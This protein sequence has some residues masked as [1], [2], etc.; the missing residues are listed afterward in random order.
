[1]KYN[2]DLQKLLIQYI[3]G[4]CSAEE[5]SRV[6]R[7]IREDPEIK[8]EF[9][10][11]KATW[12]QTS[13]FEL[14]ANKPKSWKKITRKIEDE[15]EKETPIYELG[16]VGKNKFEAAHERKK[17]FKRFITRSWCFSVAAALFL[18]ALASYL[19]FP[20]QVKSLLTDPNPTMR[21]ISTLPGERVSVTF[22]DGS[23]VK[24]NGASLIRLPKEFSGDTREVK[25]LKGEA[26][27]DVTTNREKPFIVHTP[28][29]DVEV[30]GTKFNINAYPR[31][32]NVQV[33]VAEGKVAVRSNETAA[34]KMPDEKQEVLLTSGQLTTV[35]E[36]GLPAEPKQT[37]LLSHI[38]WIDNIIVFESASLADVLD[39]LSNYY[40]VSFEVRDSTLY[41]RKLT[42][43]FR[44]EP[45]SRVL[46]VAML[47]LNI[48]YEQNGKQIILEPEMEK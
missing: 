4:N 20:S 38:G 39:R 26:Y 5:K 9:E 34:D 45:L 8:K 42:A 10:T 13:I 41:Q 25:L 17:P 27:F 36:T 46:E 35:D 1:M 30:L 11:L 15:E 24:L 43:E 28:R 47:S 32:K 14:E 21:E 16:F 44:D 19:I 40:D 7:L 29:A 12:D 22:S 6:E 2:S 23:R 33:V 37:N 18:L 48:A 31:G 3:Q